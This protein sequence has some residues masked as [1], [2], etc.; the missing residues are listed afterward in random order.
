M[1]ATLIALV[2]NGTWR[3]TVEWPDLRDVEETFGPAAGEEVLVEEIQDV[4]AS[5]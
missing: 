2:I 4:V 3:S 1:Y 5:E